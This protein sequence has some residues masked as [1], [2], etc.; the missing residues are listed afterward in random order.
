M[1]KHIAKHHADVVK[2]ESNESLSHRDLDQP[3]LKKENQID[4]SEKYNDMRTTILKNT[5]KKSRNR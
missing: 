2:I 5:V 3:L 1:F 4:Q